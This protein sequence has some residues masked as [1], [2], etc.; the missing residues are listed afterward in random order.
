MKEYIDQRVLTPSMFGDSKLAHDL[1]KDV[2]IAM[3]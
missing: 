3:D 2:K 1:D